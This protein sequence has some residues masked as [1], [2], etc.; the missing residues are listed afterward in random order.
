VSRP[1]GEPMVR[2]MRVTGLGEGVDCARALVPVAIERTLAVLREYRELLD[3]YDVHALRMVGTSALRDAS[4]RA[5]F[6]MAAEE[7]AG[8]RLTLLSGAEEAHLSFLGATSELADGSG[9]W[10]VADIG[11][12]STELV[13]GEQ[14]DEVLAGR[15]LDLGCVRVTERFF[16]HDPPTAEELATATGWLTDQYAEADLPALR[17][18]G[19]LIGLAGTV[20]ALACFDQGLE[21]YDHQVVHHYGLSREAVGR[22]LRELAA[23]PASQRSGLPGIERG[24][25]PVIV[26]GTLVL[27]SLMAHFGFEECLV[28]ESDILDG[29]VIT[30]LRG[31]EGPGPPR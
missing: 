11:G 17:S 27:A 2:L 4:N 31:G 16:H 12:G 28:S 15:S 26:G 10:L 19:T 21:T 5:S 24:R 18:A 13:V 29:L 8:T 20:S 23:L 1:N 14:P 30:L 6:S 9:P 7:I 25:A 22:A 3:L